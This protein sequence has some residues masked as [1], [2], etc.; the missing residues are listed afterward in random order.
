[1]QHAAWTFDPSNISWILQKFLFS[2]TSFWQ[3]DFFNISNHLPDSFFDLCWH[4]PWMTQLLTLGLLFQFHGQLALKFH[5]DKTCFF[6]HLWHYKLHWNY[7]IS[8]AKTSLFVN[9]VG[10]SQG[11][12]LLDWS[13]LGQVR[14]VRHRWVWVTWHPSIW[15]WSL[16]D[17]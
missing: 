10:G 2:H 8:H 17:G 12:Q 5:W 15:C 13:N 11:V 14:A 6:W 9:C 1:M 16:W 3:E 4:L 7:L